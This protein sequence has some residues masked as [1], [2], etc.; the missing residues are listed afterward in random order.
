MRS[1]LKREKYS[2][3]SFSSVYKIPTCQCY[4]DYNK[5][6]AGRS[7]LVIVKNLIFLKSKKEFVYF[8][9]MLEMIEPFLINSLTSSLSILFHTQ[10]K[11]NCIADTCKKVIEEEDYKPRDFVGNINDI[12]QY[13]KKHEVVFITFRNSNKTY[14]KLGN[15]KRCNLIKL[16]L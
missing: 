16:F 1:Y 6:L 13:I 3:I 12:V 8:E 9:K 11:K 2:N 15:C 5:S 7:W 4:P 14:E 10:C